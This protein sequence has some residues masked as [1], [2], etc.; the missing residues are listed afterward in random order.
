MSKG[1]PMYTRE[2]FERDHRIKE[3]RERQDSG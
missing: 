3:E 1:R 2:M